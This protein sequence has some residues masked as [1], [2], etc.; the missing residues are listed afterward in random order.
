MWNYPCRIDVEAS[1]MWP[2]DIIWKTFFSKNHSQNGVEKLFPDLFLKNQNQ[3]YL[4]I[5]SDKF[6]TVYMPNWGLS[7]YIETKLQ[8]IC[9]YLKWSLWKKNKK[10]SAIN[11]LPSFSAWFLKKCCCYV[12]LT[13]Q[14]SLHGCL[15]FVRYWTICVL[16]LFISQVVT[17]WILKLTLHF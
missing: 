1:K 11:L 7:K 6:S 17:T 8:T 12:I 13:D 10:R 16:Q 14:I 3:G 15:Y 5:N 2:L 9:Y 4:W